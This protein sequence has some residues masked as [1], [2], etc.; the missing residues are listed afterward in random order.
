MK[1]VNR[2]GNLVERNLKKFALMIDAIHSPVV[3][4][5]MQLVFERRRVFWIVI[6]MRLVLQQNCVRWRSLFKY[7]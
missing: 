4:F 5:V 6:E 1:F 7:G 2:H 3:E